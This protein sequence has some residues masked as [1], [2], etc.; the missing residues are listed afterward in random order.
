MI[1]SSSSSTVAAELEAVTEVEIIAY[2]ESSGTGNFVLE[3]FESLQ[4]PVSTN[5]ESIDTEDLKKYADEFG[6]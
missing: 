5:L 3:D 4:I 2:L 6:I 1:N